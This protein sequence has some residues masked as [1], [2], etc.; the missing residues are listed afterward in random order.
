MKKIFN[1]SVVLLLTVLLGCKHDALVSK[2][3]LSINL[4]DKT[5]SDNTT[6]CFTIDDLDC[7]G[8]T[9][10]LDNCPETYNPNQ[11][12][13]DGDG[14]GD[15][16]DPTPYGNGSPGGSGT[17]GY[18]SAATYYNNYCVVNG[19]L[20]YNCGLARGIKE[21]LEETPPIFANT[22]VYA[23]TTKYFKIDTVSGTTTQA[24]DATYCASKECY[25]TIGALELSNDPFLIRQA[26]VDWLNGKTTYIDGL[27]ADYPNLSS[28]YNGYRAGVVEGF[29]FYG[30]NLTTFQIP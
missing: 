18:V 29:W 12:D 21:V 22:T 25:V 2:E 16:C 11:E 19:I 24:G 26:N 30:N 3:D 8:I 6:P 17:S 15:V 28:Y 4:K 5:K 27:K 14:I 20:D 23:T 9:D 7:D 1:V 10:S 13:T